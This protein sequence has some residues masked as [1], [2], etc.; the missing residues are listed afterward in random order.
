MTISIITPVWNRSDL[1]ARWLS[2]NWRQYAAVIL[3]NHE[4][5]E[6]IIIDNGSTDD[7]QDILTH[8]K[9][10]FGKHLKIITLKE[11]TGF[12]PANN[13]G[14]EIATGD[15]LAFISND[16]QV[17]GDYITPIEVAYRYAQGKVLFGPEIWENNTGWNTFNPVG[18]IPYVAG[19]CVVVEASLWGVMCKWDERYVPCDYED[20][21]L[22][23]QTTRAGGVLTK[24]SLPL[25][26]DSGKSAEALPGGRLPVTLANQKRFMEK[27]GLSFES[28]A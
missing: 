9:T 15:A 22:S 28:G 21:D 10:M 17:T 4:N 14:A 24:L 6:W 8:W 5:A 2:Q 27:W 20:I 23:H 18:T 16:V 12:G 25:H 19:W 1:T 13:R 3:A 26:H 11:N 7:T